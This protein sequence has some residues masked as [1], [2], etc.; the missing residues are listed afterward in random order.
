MNRG[1][2][3]HVVRTE[4]ADISRRT[5]LGTT[6]AG[7]GAILAGGLGSSFGGFV[8]IAAGAQTEDAIW[9]EKSI[10]ELRSLM[11]SGDLTSLQLT[12]GYLK[13]IKE[14]NPLLH[15]VIETNPQAEAIAARLD[16]ERRR[17][18]SRGP[19]HGIPILVK[20]NIATDDAM[21]TTAGSRALV[22]SRVPADATIVAGCARPGP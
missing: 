5:F 7:A 3:R 18:Q 6:A 10:P 19:L 13:R 15:A 21:Q 2:P 4:T 14:L 9:I 17:G 8:P 12:R 11:A 16:A 22:N 20:D 1:A